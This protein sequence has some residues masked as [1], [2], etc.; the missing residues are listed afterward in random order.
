MRWR[1]GGD[2]PSVSFSS[3]H[4]RI[5]H[6]PYLEDH[7]RPRDVRN[8]VSS[9]YQAVGARNTSQVG[10]FR[11][12]GPEERSFNKQCRLD[13]LGQICRASG[14]FVC[15]SIPTIKC[16]Q[17]LSEEARNASVIIEKRKILRYAFDAAIQSL[18]VPKVLVHVTSASHGYYHEGSSSSS[19]SCLRRPRQAA[20]FLHLFRLWSLS[21][22][23]IWRR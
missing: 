20:L 23:E 17:P 12:S 9:E 6:S 2:P 13:M 11:P 10:E 5:L 22:E 18:K 21:F 15:F 3:K 4:Q 1:P 8:E 7:S 16:P 19:V 14:K